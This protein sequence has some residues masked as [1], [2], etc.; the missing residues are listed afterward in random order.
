MLATARGASRTPPPLQPNP[1]LYINKEI[2]YALLQKMYDARH[3]TRY[4]L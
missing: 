2:S 4:H 1:I 3:P